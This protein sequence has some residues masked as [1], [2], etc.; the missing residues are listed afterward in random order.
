MGGF[1]SGRRPNPFGDHALRRFRKQR[2]AAV[3]ARNKET[4]EPFDMDDRD[5]SAYVVEGLLR[6]DVSAFI[7][8]AQRIR[9]AYTNKRKERLKGKKYGHQS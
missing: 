6:R 3:T 7:R 2:R 9:A 5:P 4:H 1:G 8:H